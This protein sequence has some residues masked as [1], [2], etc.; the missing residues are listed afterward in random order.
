MPAP[1]GM[2]CSVLPRFVLRTWFI[3][4]DPN[5]GGVRCSL[6]GLL[7]RINQIGKYNP[8]THD[9]N[10]RRSAE[11]SQSAKRLVD[12]PCQNM[13]RLIKG[14]WGR[15]VISITDLHALMHTCRHGITL[16]KRFW[17]WKKTAE[18]RFTSFWI[19]S[20]IRQSKL[21]LIYPRTSRSCGFIY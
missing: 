2:F 3:N 8:Y 6:Q 4:N 19:R 20:R 12:Y 18:Q 5:F 21:S 16:Q 9:S 7:G 15:D 14:V 10:R 1:A 13:G 17:T 11:R